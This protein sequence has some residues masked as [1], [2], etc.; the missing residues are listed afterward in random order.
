MD[1]NKFSALKNKSLNEFKLLG[2]PRAAYWKSLTFTIDFCAV[3]K[4]WYI[5]AGSVYSG[6]VVVLK[7]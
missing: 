2:S 5:N 7:V 6:D 3:M 1:R 4:P